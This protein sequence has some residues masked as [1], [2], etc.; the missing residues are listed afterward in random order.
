MTLLKGGADINAKTLAGFTPLHLAV[1]GRHRLTVRTLLGNSFAPVDVHSDSVHGT[2]L[3]LTKD[4]EIRAL[5]LEYSHYGCLKS[6]LES[7]SGMP[8]PKPKRSLRLSSSVSREF[9]ES[10][11]AAPTPK[12]NRILL[13]PLLTRDLSG[14]A[15]MALDLSISD[16]Q[17]LHA[18]ERQQLNAF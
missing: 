9:S 2:P 16:R 18:I 4:A 11:S 7:E 5:L 17:Q 3:E 1:L 13:Q 10:G 6:A 14:S 15:K 8:T 12:T